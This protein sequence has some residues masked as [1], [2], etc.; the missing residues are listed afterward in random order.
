[1]AL[2]LICTASLLLS[3]CSLLS[4]AATSDGIYTTR[5]VHDPDGIGKFYMGREIAQVMGHQGAYWL[6][7]P[8]RIL[9][10]KPLWAIAAL[11]LQQ[12]EVIADIGAGTGFLSIRIAERYPASTIYAVDV[13]P[14]MLDI[15]QQR[16]EEFAGNQIIPTLGSETNVN[17]PDNSVDIAVMLDAYHEFAYPREMMESLTHALKPD[18]RVALVEYRKENPFIPIKPAHKMSQ[19]QARKELR[20]VG[21]QWRETKD[22]LPQQHLMVF[23]C[24]PGVCGTR[25]ASP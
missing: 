7:R 4:E 11:D 18:G 22:L 3:S 25:Q 8:S 19:R 1:M 17:L 16:S 15:L 20:S 5:T 23:E 21:L 13:Q 9:E 10:E 6:E 24:A 14:E 12:D 2:A